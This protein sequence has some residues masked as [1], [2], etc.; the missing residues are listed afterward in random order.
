MEAD[1]ETSERTSIL[2]NPQVQPDFALREG[3]IRTWL[4][5]CGQCRTSVIAFSLER[6]SML[7]ASSFAKI[8]KKNSQ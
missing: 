6:G 5:Q 7:G 4:K 1:C 3:S 2:S 8:Q